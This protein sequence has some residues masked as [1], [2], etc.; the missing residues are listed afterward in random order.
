MR[1]VCQIHALLLCTFLT[2][3]S[4]NPHV[5]AVVGSGSRRRSN[6]LF[7]GFFVRVEYKVA[8][9]CGSTW[10]VLGCV[11]DTLRRLLRITNQRIIVELTTD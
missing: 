2:H 4:R 6:H 9:F 3:F 8:D 10:C 7:G 1:K 11:S 5:T